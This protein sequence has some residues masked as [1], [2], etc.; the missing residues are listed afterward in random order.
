MDRGLASALGC[1][2]AILVLV[3]P[4]SISNAPEQIFIWGAF[5]HATITYR[6]LGS[7][8]PSES[9]DA[10]AAA[11]MWNRAI[12]AYANATPAAGYLANLSFQPS[13]LGPP[14]DVTVVIG[15]GGQGNTAPVGPIH[16][17][18]FL[19]FDSGLPMTPAGPGLL[20]ASVV[21]LPGPLVDT[22][23]AVPDNPP[24]HVCA[25]FE[26]CHPVSLYVRLHELGH[27]LGLGHT[28]DGCS[29]MSQTPSCPE[30]PSCPGE[31][32]CYC[33]SELELGGI[34]TAY[35]WL[36]SGSSILAFEPPPASLSMRADRFF[37]VN[38]PPGP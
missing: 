1:A 28:L 4:V 18:A 32:P 25:P 11:H 3:S 5:N 7:L 23:V 8:V 10:E 27:S 19:M 34:A 12:H 29:I 30:M 14:A 9:N 35:H 16:P 13:L 31:Q 21:N 24:E 33:F 38:V 26:W 2:S 37:C 15:S 6:V 20:L 36:A 22:D 17:D